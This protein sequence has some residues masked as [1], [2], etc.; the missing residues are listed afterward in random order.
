MSRGTI[1]NTAPD[2]AKLTNKQ[3]SVNTIVCVHM[4]SKFE[5]RSVCAD[6]PGVGNRGHSG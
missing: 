2:K 6:Q 1:N 4:A 5:E 3:G